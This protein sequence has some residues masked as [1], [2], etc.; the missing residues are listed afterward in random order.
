MENVDRTINT[1]CEWVQGNLNKAGSTEQSMFLPE[2]TKALAELVS[3]RA[4][5]EREVNH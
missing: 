3:A 4:N 5:A 1:I 2:M